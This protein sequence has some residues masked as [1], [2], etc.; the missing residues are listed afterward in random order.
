MPGLGM[1]SDKRPGWLL[2]ELASA[3]RENLDTDHVARY[4]D[5]EDAQADAEVETLTSLGLNEGSTLVDLGA[6]TGQLALAAA[7]RCGRVIAVDVSPVMLDVIRAKLRTWP[8]PNVEVV[9]AG[10]L[11]YEHQGEPA[12]FIYSRWALHHLPDFWKSIALTRMRTVV[13]VGAILRL[14][15]IVY[16]FPPSEAEDR[17][18]QWCATLPD[19][20]AEGE[21]LRADIEEHVRD[22]H[23]TYT[24]LLE[25]MLERSGFRIN[26]VEYSSDGFEAKY[27]ATAV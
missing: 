20:A 22:E 19:Y 4:D 21:W 7:P 24:W 15:D 12:D 9:Q 18:E 8:L 2:D 16:S 11:S 13:G 17:I 10:F 6:G 1:R 23:S 25:P 5:K 14:S 3:G 26:N 27:I